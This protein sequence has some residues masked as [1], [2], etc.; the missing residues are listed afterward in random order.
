MSWTLAVTIHSGDCLHLLSRNSNNTSQCIKTILS[1]WT[2]QGLL[3][4]DEDRFYSEGLTLP[5]F[6]MSTR[7]LFYKKHN[8]KSLIV[9]L[10]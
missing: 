8:S 3:N 9:C 5:N 1:K 2:Q 6:N 7:E 10:I 4:G